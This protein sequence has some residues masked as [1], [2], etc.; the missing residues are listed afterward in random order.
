MKPKIVTDPNEEWLCAVGNA[1]MGYPVGI[2]QDGKPVEGVSKPALAIVFM[3]ARKVPDHVMRMIGDLIF[4]VRGREI[5]PEDLQPK[6]AED[7]LLWTIRAAA[8]FGLAG[9]SESTRQLRLPMRERL[10]LIDVQEVA[11]TLLQAIDGIYEDLPGAFPDAFKDQ[12][13][14]APSYEEIARSLR[15]LATRPVASV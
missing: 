8:L 15:R 1:L 10:R 2:H 11:S 12:G 6:T 7:L 9:K 14:D 4:G 5:L 13:E 3:S